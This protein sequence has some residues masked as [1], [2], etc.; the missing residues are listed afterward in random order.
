MKINFRRNASHRETGLIFFN[1]F[2]SQRF[3]KQTNL[4]ESDPAPAVKGLRSNKSNTKDFDGS[5]AYASL[6]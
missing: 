2:A 5:D 4:I 1:E 3:G 6:I